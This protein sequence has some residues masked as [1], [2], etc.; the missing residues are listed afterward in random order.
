MAEA[1]AVATKMIKHLHLTALNYAPRTRG[2]YTFQEVNVDPIIE[3]IP[4]G[5]YIIGIFA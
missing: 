3:Q 1:V 4:M 5:G 2:W